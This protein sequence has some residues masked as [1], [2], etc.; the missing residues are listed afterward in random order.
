MDT[1]REEQ[2]CSTVQPEEEQPVLVHIQ[3]LLQEVTQQ[4]IVIYQQH[5]ENL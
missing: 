2:K 3:L 1:V 5:P 4:V